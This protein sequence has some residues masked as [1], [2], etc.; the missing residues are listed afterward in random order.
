MKKPLLGIGFALWSLLSISVFAQN[1]SIRLAT[2]TSTYNSGLLDYLLAEFQSAEG[3]EVQVIAV[4]TGKALR[5]GQNG[6]VDVV[7]T[8]APDAEAK[9]VADGHGIEPLG[10]MYNDFII[11][12]PQ[13]DPASL[14]SLHS[15]SEGLQA[16]AIS[17]QRFLSRGDDSG[18]H[19]KELQLWQSIEAK[20]GFSGYLESGRGMGHTLQMA[21]ELQGYTL[22]D[23]G[24]WLAM[25]D[26]LDLQVLLQSDPRLLNPYQIILINPQ[27]HPHVQADLGRQF[28]HWMVSEVG[29]AAIGAF[30]IND[31]ALFV[32]SAR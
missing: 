6:D 10:V 28:Q 15:V 31:E 7:M 29:Q 27:H 16:L 8:H 5:M 32:P 9:F 21:S 1:P 4:G 23:R 26:K 14:S 11:V 12:G 2:T 25:K 20:P 17:E 19:K 3:I 18:T 13:S 24:T 30:R 22:S